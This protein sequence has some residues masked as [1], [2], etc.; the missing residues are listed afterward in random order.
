MHTPPPKRAGRLLALVL[1]LFAVPFE[2]TVAADPVVRVAALE[3]GTV[4]W[5]LD[6]IQH[7]G[8][9][10]A[11]GIQVEVH[12]VGS[13]D[14]AAVALQSGAVDVMVS[15]WLWVSRQRHSG[16]SWTLYPWSMAVG[17]IMVDPEAGIDSVDDLAGTRLGVAGGPTD[18]SWL[19]LRAYYRQ[20]HGEPLTDRVEPVFGSPPLLSQLMRRGELPAAINY[21]HYNARLDAAGMEPLIGVADM[22][23]PLGIDESVPLLGWVFDESW[24]QERPDQLR[25]FL[26]ASQQAKRR[27]ARDDREWARLRDLTQAEDDATLAA[28]R[29][30]FRAGIPR[31]FGPEEIAAARELFTILASEGGE[32]LTGGHSEL[33]EGTFWLPEQ[34]LSEWQR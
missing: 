32:D 23:P 5:E 22:L 4:R 26:Q 6:V 28:L 27:L 12:P 20:Q 34:A 24:A 30:T 9:D 14:A 19:L 29:D 18:K 15:D 25:A 33:A 8:L 7:H 31:D 17:S 21:W 13:G 1:T 2:T 11:E 10:R 16:R 3:Y